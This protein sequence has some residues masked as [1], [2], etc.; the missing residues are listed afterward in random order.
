[1][2]ER[3]GVTSSSVGAEERI[4][5]KRTQGG[6]AGRIPKATKKKRGQCHLQTWK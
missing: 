3:E 1:M 6:V 4:A 5:E 2:W